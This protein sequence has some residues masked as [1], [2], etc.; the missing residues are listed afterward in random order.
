M[1]VCDLAPPSAETITKSM[2]LFKA[3]GN[4]PVI[5]I[6]LDSYMRVLLEALTPQ[7]LLEK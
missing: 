4:T 1:M 6:Y 3:R 5:L 2:I 7:P